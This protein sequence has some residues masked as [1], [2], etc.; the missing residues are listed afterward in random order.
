MS[1]PSDKFIKLGL[2]QVL[3]YLPQ[4][5]EAQT[6]DY[7]SGYYPEAYSL[8]YYKN[9]VV[10]MPFENDFEI[11]K[12]LLTLSPTDTTPYFSNSSTITDVGGAFYSQ[13]NDPLFNVSGIKWWMAN[14]GCMIVFNSGIRQWQILSHS[15]VGFSPP[16]RAGTVVLYQGSG[17]TITYSAG[18]G[19][20]VT[21]ELQNYFP[22]QIKTW[23]PVHP[24][25]SGLVPNIVRFATTA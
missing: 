23:T 2:S 14:N 5:P 6:M 10:W 11:G 19:G 15:G 24:L 16:N 13:G 17:E 18:P 1:E 25:A 20:I 21:Q 3:Q 4:F 8:T 12:C 7:W 9:R 22:W